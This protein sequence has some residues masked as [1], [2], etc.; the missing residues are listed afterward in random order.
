MNILEFI[1]SRYI[2]N[3][4]NLS[5]VQPIVDVN[6]SYYTHAVLRAENTYNIIPRKLYNYEAL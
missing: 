1:S 3:N 5:L 2:K 6:M 4:N